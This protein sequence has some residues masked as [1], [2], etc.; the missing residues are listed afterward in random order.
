[1]RPHIYRTHD[2]GATWTEI[3]TGIPNG[4]TVNAVREDPR[5]KGLLFAGTERAVYVSFD[6]G[7]RWQPLRLN[8]AASSVRDLI[9][10]DD[11]LVTATHGRGFWILDDITPLRQIDASSVAKDL[12][13]FEPT[14]AWRVRWNTSTDMPWPKEEP[15]GANPPDGA[16]INYYLKSAASGPVTLEIRRADGRLVR[17]YS[18]DDPVTPIPDAKTAPVP[19]YWYRPPQALSTAAGMHRFLWDVHYQPIAGAGG[20][21]RGGLP[22]QGIPY[23][24]PSGA[25]TPWVS[26][27]TYTVTLT[28]GGKSDTQPITVKQDP[29]VETPAAVMQQVYALTDAMYFGA[30]EAQAAAAEISAMR[31]QAGKIQAQ[32]PAAQALAAFMQKATAL[33]GQRAAAGSGGGRGAMGGGRGELAAPAAAD[34]LWAVSTSLAGQMNAMQAADV[35]PTATTLAAATAA[36]GAADPVMARWGSLKTVDLPALNATLKAAGLPP[37]GGRPGLHA[38]GG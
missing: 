17:R 8:M 31:E 28:A 25:T 38:P 4:E 3:V 10:K 16:I 12:I 30:V 27:G 37:I 35:A 19:T 22:I 9:V 23:N 15:T 21:G 29:R 7:A 5:R 34:S 1:M 33:E 18:S 11:D 26:P 20:G 6:D 36:L 14:A 13:L 24:S 32:G 2:G